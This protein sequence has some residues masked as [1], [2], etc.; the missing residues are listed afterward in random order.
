MFRHSSYGRELAE[1]E[2]R[3]QQLERRLDSFGRAAG[4]SSAGIAQATDRMGEALVS[5]LSDIVERFRGGARS[6]GGE[7]SR[8]GLE[9]TRFGQEATKL[10]RDAV[11]R[12]ASEVERRPLAMLAMA[13]GIGL[14]VGLAGR[15]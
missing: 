9:A 5:A 1:M 7:A 14:L 4:R 3:M 10:G 6:V 8:F 12:V 2:R 15:R 13:A 11:R